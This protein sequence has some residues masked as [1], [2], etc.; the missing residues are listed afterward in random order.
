MGF[1]DI[2]NFNLALLG[3]QVWRLLHN[4]DSLLY[5]VFKAKF[6]SNCSILDDDV[7]VS[8]SYAWQSILKAREVVKRG[9][10]WRI[11]DGR[12]ARIRGDKWL[13]DK[14]SSRVISPQKN[15]PNNALVCASIDED[16]P[17]WD[18]GRVLSEFF[19]HEAR[20]ILGIPLSSRQ[21]SDKLIWAGTKSGKYTTKSAYKLL[22]GTPTA[23]PSNPSAHSSFWKQIWELEVPNKIKHF[24]WRACC[25]SLPSKKNLFTKKVTRNATCDLCHDGVEDAIHALWGCQVLKEVWWEEPCLRN[26]LAVQFVEFRDL[27]I[28]IAERFAY[29]ACSIWHNRNA[30]KMK[31]T[32]IPYN[33]IYGDMLD[34]F[35]EYQSAQQS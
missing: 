14:F 18:E 27:W 1:R 28:G 11:G 17:C 30:T 29:V 32:C 4:T 34:R 2:E 21:V 12:Q 5:K 23:G 24:I 26:Q 9:S 19:P 31:T 6:F 20:A 15:L 33:K 16:G 7:K 3:K 13:P 10:I 22:S 35:K 8:G 25:E